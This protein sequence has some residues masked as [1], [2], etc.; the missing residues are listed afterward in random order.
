MNQ[1]HPKLLK[2]FTS[3][4]LD[5]MADHSM[6]S[7]NKEEQIYVLF[8]LMDFGSF[9]IYCDSEDDVIIYVN[10]D[11]TSD[12]TRMNNEEFWGLYTKSKPQECVS[13][14]IGF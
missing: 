4:Q 13:I 5:I 10:F 12:G 3:D 14:S 2:I 11:K 8:S 7:L 6:C 1:Y 9:E